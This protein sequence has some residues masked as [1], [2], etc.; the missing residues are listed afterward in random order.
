LQK[1]QLLE[2]DAFELGNQFTIITVEIDGQQFA[3]KLTET[4]SYRSI[5][6]VEHLLNAIGI[7]ACV[8][9]GI[10]LAKGETEAKYYSIM[11]SQKC[12]EVSKR[13]LWH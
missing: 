5:Y 3:A 11:N 9:I 10:A 7:K 13:K 1:L 6:T 2:E 4:E 8:S 12:P